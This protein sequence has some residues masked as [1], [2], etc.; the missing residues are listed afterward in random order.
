MISALLSRRD[1]LVSCVAASATALMR[2]DP[3]CSGGRHARVGLQ[4]GHP[5]PRR[6][7]DASRVLKAIELKDTPDAIVAFDE[8]RQIP[9][10]VDGI[11][12]HCGCATQPGFYSL[13]SCYETADAMARSCHVC[14]G[15]GR[16]AFRLYKSGKSLGEIR[17]AIDSR[18]G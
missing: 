9:Q 12:C 4:G 8:V 3:V 16:Y 11:R 10:I 2:R 13:L 5:T 15:Q 18:F 1:F 14:Q 17:A 7:R 6:G